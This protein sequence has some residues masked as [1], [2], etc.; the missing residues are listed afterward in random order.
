MKKLINYVILVSLSMVSFSANGEIPLTFHTVMLK[1]Y[2]FENQ[3]NQII[4]TA[5]ALYE[6]LSK[7]LELDTDQAILP[8]TPN[9]F[10]S[11]L[12]QGENILLFPLLKRA[13]R[14]E[15]AEWVFHINDASGNFIALKDR[16]FPPEMDNFKTIKD[17][18]DTSVAV[19]RG[20]TFEIAMKKAGL[21]SSSLRY[22]NTAEQGLNQLLFKRVQFLFSSKA[23]I[24]Q[25]LAM[26][27]YSDMAERVVIKEPLN[28]TKIYMAASKQ[29]DPEL[30][31]KV[32][33][34]LTEM[35][36]EGT[37]ANILK[38]NGLD[39]PGTL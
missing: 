19:V 8:L 14:D 26:P 6:Q 24:K 30:L 29:F 38:D 16:E 25:L 5:A 27:K 18:V 21:D 2:A 28:K 35:M 1:P 11:T 7:K 10:A 33:K 17:L 20:S 31:A 15:Y 39:L 37:L 12:K 23:T 3:D 22:V 4:G 9:K 13:S 34:G 36:E 32:K